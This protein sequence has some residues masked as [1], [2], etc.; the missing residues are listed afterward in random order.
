MGQFFRAQVR[1]AFGY[2]IVTEAI[3]IGLWGVRMIECSADEAS[4]LLAA[5]RG[6]G[7]KEAEL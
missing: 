5:R 2:D 3:A 4:K 1:L 7:S 6:A